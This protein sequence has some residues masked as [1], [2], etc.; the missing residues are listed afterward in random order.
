MPKRGMRA[1]KLARPSHKPDMISCLASAALL[2]GVAGCVPPRATAKAHISASLEAY[3]AGHCDLEDVVEHAGLYGTPALVKL[4]H[5]LFATLIPGPRT[6][7]IW[8]KDGAFRSGGK[9]S[10]REAGQRFDVWWDDYH[11]PGIPER[12]RL[13]LRAC[14]FAPK[15]VDLIDEAFD[16]KKHMVEV[17]FMPVRTYSW[18]GRQLRARGLLTGNNAFEPMSGYESTAWLKEASP[19]VWRVESSS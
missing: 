10:Y 8:R 17:R 4:R 7:I 6:R 19:G 14:L 15:K 18:I 5:W 11:P 2:L 13:V 12:N 16:D 1:S 3:T 9:L